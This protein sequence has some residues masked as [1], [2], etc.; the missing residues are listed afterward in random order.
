[1]RKTSIY[2]N[3]Y[4]NIMENRKPNGYWNYKKC[5]EE[6]LKY[7]SISEL[8]KISGGS[9]HSILK[10]KWYELLNPLYVK[11][12][13]GYWDYEKCKEEAL[14]YKS[15]SEAQRK[16][17][18]MYNVIGSN[19]WYELF[20]HMEPLGNRYKRLV[21]VYE[22]NDNHAYIGLTGNIKRRKIQHT[23]GKDKSSVFNHIKKTGLK[24]ICILKSEYIDVKLAILLEEEIKQEYKNDGWKILN[25]TKTGGIG[26]H[27]LKWTYEKCSEEALKYKTRSEFQIKSKSAYN[28]ALKNNWLNDICKHMIQMKVPNN[29]W[30]NNKELCK[31]ESLKYNTRTNLQLG[32]W[33][34][35][36]E[37][38]NNKWLDE[39]FPLN[40]QK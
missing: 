19:K 28:S 12:P 10:N 35:Y 5:K 30:K 2:I 4:I 7:K 24:P 26:A 37:S 40:Y 22:F 23:V 31:L 38:L 21:Y 8:F 36:N 6:A 32:S 15:R 17:A 13:N 20:S 29:F 11:K 16:C 34:C 9:Y 14:K 27:I 33:A 25:K 39:F 3:K 1:M 18:S